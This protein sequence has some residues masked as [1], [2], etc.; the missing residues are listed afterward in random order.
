[1]ANAMVTSVA[2]Q[3][4]QISN[5]LS[6]GQ[7]QIDFETLLSR[8]YRPSKVTRLIPHDK[9][10]P[11]NEES[12]K[13]KNKKKK[14][15]QLEEY[16]LKLWGPGGGGGNGVDSSLDELRKLK[17]DQ[18][19][20]YTDE[21]TSRIVL[22]LVTQT[23]AF[24]RHLPEE[25]I[26][27]QEQTR[28]KDVQV[29]LNE[30]G[31][32]KPPP[33]K[34][35]QQLIQ[36]DIPSRFHEVELGNWE[37]KI[38][39]KGCASDSDD[40]EN[41]EDE[42]DDGS[43]DEV[44]ND[45]D[46]RDN[47]SMKKSSSPQSTKVGIRSNSTIVSAEDNDEDNTTIINNMLNR[48][49][50]IELLER[51]R[52]PLLDNLIL[53]ETTVSWTGDPDD[54]LEKANRVPLILELGVA[55]RSVGRFVYQNTALS[56]QRPMP[57]LK[58]DAYLARV[59]R[60]WSTQQPSL[61]MMSPDDALA[62]ASKGSLHYDKEKMQALIEAKQKKRAQMA[63]DKKDRVAEAMGT[64]A[65]GGGRG[66]T[67][68]SSLMGPGGT[69]RTGRPSRNVAV[70][71]AHETLYIEQLDLVNNHSLYKDLSKVM[72]R[73][74]LR[75]KLP[76]SLVRQ[77]LIWQF[78]HRYVTSNKKDGSSQAGGSGQGGSGSGGN[79]GTAGGYLNQ[80]PVGA[81]GSYIGANQNSKERFRTESDLSPTEGKL[82]LL[83]YCEERPPVQL[84]KGMCSKIVN[85]YRGDKA[86]CPVSAGMFF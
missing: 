23:N 61:D 85:Y 31:G 44:D 56:A 29:L 70:G 26:Q 40:D 17:Q 13:E 55:G 64:M 71:G 27:H 4:Q 51:K 77:G 46:D 80:G 67:V 74:Y 86:R 78:Q 16:K 14:K 57:A 82:I 83:E 69:E 30:L 38:N 8:G 28:Q 72:L 7:S 35:I 21:I 36:S 6:S 50:A 45:A 54:L 1:M 75:P 37:S 66:R 53:D 79:T 18:Q 65:L 59:E 9:Y 34:P 11:E 48:S 39:W 22:K 58:S 43:T 42:D 62:M 52:N 19:Q 12:K 3:Q 2:Q 32:P 81:S 68:T 73:Q 84:T 49:S 63:E 15:Q 5:L 33:P 10:Q 41:D 25:V 60:E 76:Y 24:R 20:A 47:T